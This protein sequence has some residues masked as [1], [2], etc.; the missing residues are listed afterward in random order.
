M[1]FI[2]LLYNIFKYLKKCNPHLCKSIKLNY[3]THILEQ[4]SFYTFMYEFLFNCK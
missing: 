2:L 4:Y 1:Y 3:I